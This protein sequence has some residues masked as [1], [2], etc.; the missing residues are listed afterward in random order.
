MSKEEA[1]KMFPDSNECKADLHKEI[2]RVRFSN[3]TKDEKKEGGY[4]DFLDIKRVED[5]L[6]AI[7]RLN[8]NCEDNMKR[9][10]SMML[11]LKGIIAMVRPSA[12]KNAWYGE[13][14]ESVSVT[15]RCPDHPTKLI[16]TSCQKS[17]D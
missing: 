10:N 12:K 7:E 9:L 13:E 4:I 2:P 16:S 15:N 6:R 3:L 8:A 14:I 1:K 5:M 17:K 11:E